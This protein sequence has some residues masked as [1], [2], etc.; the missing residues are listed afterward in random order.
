MHLIQD[1]QFPPLLYKRY[2]DDITV[3]WTHGRRRP[4]QLLERFNSTYDRIKFTYELSYDEGYID[5]MDVTI[6]IQRSG[7]RS[8]KLFQKPCNSGL[9]IDY[10]AAVPQH[11][12]IAVAKSQFLTAQRLSSNAQ[13]H[14]ERDNKIQRQLHNTHYSENIISEA[15]EA[16]RKPRRIRRGNPRLLLCVVEL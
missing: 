9:L 2:I 3:L 15:R 5:Y 8:Y 1:S 10:A 6:A 16:A 7:E 14:A 4:M 13:M 11:V 12:K